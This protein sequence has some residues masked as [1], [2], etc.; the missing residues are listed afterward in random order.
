ML[1]EHMNMDNSGAQRVAQFAFR[2]KMM[3]KAKV[4]SC[5]VKAQRPSQVSDVVRWKVLKAE[6]KLVFPASGKQTAEEKL[7]KLKK[8]GSET[9]VEFISRYMSAA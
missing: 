5:F 1:C 4:L 8:N 3:Y 9:L 6:L 2:V 7:K